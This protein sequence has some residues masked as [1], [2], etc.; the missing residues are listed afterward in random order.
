MKK[1]RSE[2]RFGVSWAEGQALYRSLGL[3]DEDLAKPHIGIITSWNDANP[4]HVHL[5]ELAKA[6]EIGIISAG[7]LPFNFNT[8]GLCDGIGLVGGEYLLPHRDLMTNEVEVI[9]EGN[10]LDAI[11]LLATCDKIVPAF[12]MAAARLDV[13]AIMVTGG[14]MKSGELDGKKI[15]FVDVGKAVGAVQSG[16]IDQ[17][18]FNRIIDC[19]CPG[20]GACPMMGTAN[21]MCIVAEALGMSLPGNST[22][23]AASREL[24]ALAY[25][26]G[27]RIVELWQEGITARQIITDCA[28]ANAIKVIMAMGGSTNTLVHIPAIASEA[29]LELD[30]AKTFDTASNQIHLLMSISPSGPYLMEDFERAGGLGALCRQIFPHLAPE[31]LTVTGKTLGEN[32]AGCE[33]KDSSVIRPL[34]DPVSKEGAIAVLRGNITPDG[35]VVKQSAVPAHMLKFRGPARVFNSCDEAIDGLRGGKIKAGDVVVI[36]FHGARGGPGLTTTFP[37]TSELAGSPLAGLVALVTDG[38]FSGA[39]EGACI[40]YASPEAALYGPILAVHDGDIIEYDIP[41]RTLNALLTQEEIEK[42]LKEAEVHIQIRR[43]YLGIYQSV[44]GSCL[45]GAILRGK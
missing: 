30:C 39:T 20:A 5:R 23:R 13:P 36:L 26:A 6:V 22:L 4:G 9:V 31:T 44:V 34:S 15:S 25:R 28:V 10:R 8:I 37:F 11:V 19:A 3:T 35:A 41:A 17:K 16:K 24:V 14:Y 38:R 1:L 7:G 29:E 27:V 18:E 2:Q 32:Y 40:G 45:K 42:R 21:T 33:V 12:L 43:G